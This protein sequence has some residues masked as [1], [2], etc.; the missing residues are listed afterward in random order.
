MILTDPDFW[1]THN[2]VGFSGMDTRT[3]PVWYR[4]QRNSEGTNNS[5]SFFDV[6]ADTIKNGFLQSRDVLVL[7]NATFHNGGENKAFVEW[8]WTQFDIFVAW[9]RTRSP[10]LNPI[11]LIWGLSGKKTANVPPNNLSNKYAS[12]RMLV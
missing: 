7:D 2:L 10:E 11:E 3:N 6:T 4:I 1:N 9:L 8:L 5:G 12:A